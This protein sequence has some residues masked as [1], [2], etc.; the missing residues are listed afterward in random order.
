MFLENN[1]SIQATTDPL[2]VHRNTPRYRRGQIEELL[3]MDL[4]DSAH[5][6]NLW[7]AFAIID[8]AAARDGES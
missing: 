6:A 4:D 8:D 5:I 7:L 2:Y 3:E 1:R